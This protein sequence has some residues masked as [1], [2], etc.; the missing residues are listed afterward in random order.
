VEKH[1]AC[2]QQSASERAKIAQRLAKQQAAM[3]KAK[4]MP[5]THCSEF[6]SFLAAQ[7]GYRGLYLS[8]TEFGALPGSGANGG[9]VP[10]S[11]YPSG[12]GNRRTADALYNFLAGDGAR[13]DGWT[14]VPVGE[15]IGYANTGHLVFGAVR[16][17]GLPAEKSGEPRQNGHIFA[18]PNGNSWSDSGDSGQIRTLKIVHAAMGSTLP[19]D[20]TLS[21]TIPKAAY[22]NVKYFVWLN[23]LDR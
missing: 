21:K 1:L 15:A 22:T 3:E 14:S 4:E 13:S 16:S 19:T 17:D 5:T 23:R 8:G 2:S 20:S 7:Y 9:I 6:A 11:G 18:I 10:G 12:G